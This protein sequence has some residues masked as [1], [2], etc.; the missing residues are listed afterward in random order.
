[1]PV[2]VL[3]CLIFG[4]F[5]SI[6]AYFAIPDNITADSQTGRLTRLDGCIRTYTD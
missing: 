2:S 6:S 5:P 3:K 1:M 4:V